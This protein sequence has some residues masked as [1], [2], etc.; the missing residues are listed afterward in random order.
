[1]TVYYNEI[2]KYC[3]QWLR[4]LIDAR[5]IAHGVVDERSI[6]DVK[7]DDLAGYTQ[8]HFFAGIGV[9]SL[10]L[11]NAGW[12][13][14][15]EI[16]TASCPC[17][18]FSTAGKGAGFNDERHLWPHLQWLIQ[19]CRPAKVIGEQVAS[20]DAEPWIDLVHADLEA[21]GYVF[22]CVPFPSA[23][24]GAPHIRDRIYWVGNTY[25][26]RT[27]GYGKYREIIFQGG[28]QDEERHP[29]SSNVVAGF[30][31][32][33][34]PIKGADGNIRVLPPCFGEVSDVSASAV[35]RLRAYGNAINA[36][37]AQV[38]IESVMEIILIN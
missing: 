6:E 31:G 30:W 13:D 16:W 27:Q 33:W 3:A 32:E 22:G 12:A 25:D 9:W 34:K 1:M 7:P 21:M 2:N 4:N 23:G 26:T 10:A 24:V 11:R 37:Q 15:R 19:Q 38:F 17:Q 18:P 36:T 29:I 8:C 20:K 14:D 5:Q 28:R 35:G